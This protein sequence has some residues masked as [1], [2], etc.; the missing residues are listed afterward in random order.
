MQVTTTFSKGGKMSDIPTQSYLTKDELEAVKFFYT[1]PGF[2][3]EEPYV[4]EK[5]F[6]LTNPNDVKDFSLHEWTEMFQGTG[7]VEWE[8]IMAWWFVEA[9][10]SAVDKKTMCDVSRI[11]NTTFLAIN[12]YCTPRITKRLYPSDVINHIG[13]YFS[14]KESIEIVYLT[15]KTPVP[16]EN[17]IKVA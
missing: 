13:H 9:I 16:S 7:H 14:I 5:Q 10:R 11:F 6:I 4:Q 3:F 2:D 1:G 15:F 17:Q 12:L 8:V